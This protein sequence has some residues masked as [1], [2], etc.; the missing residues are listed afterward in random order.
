MTT[1]FFINFLISLVNLGE[2]YLRN[3]EYIKI[4]S[5]CFFFVYTNS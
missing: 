4:K 2:Y 5:H 1:L 3:L